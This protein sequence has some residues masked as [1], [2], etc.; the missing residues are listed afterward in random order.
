MNTQL[1]YQYKQLKIM[2]ETLEAEWIEHKRLH[3][4]AVVAQTC[5]DVQPI[6]VPLESKQTDDVGLLRCCTGD[7]SLTTSQTCAADDDLQRQ[8]S[9]SFATRQDPALRRPRGFG[10]STSSKRPSHAEF[11][12][13]SDAVSRVMQ[14]FHVAVDDQQL[15]RS[16]N[17]KS[18]SSSPTLFYCVDDIYEHPAAVLE[19]TSSLVDGQPAFRAKNNNN[20]D[21]DDSLESLFG[22]DDWWTTDESCRWQCGSPAGLSVSEATRTDGGSTKLKTDDCLLT[23]PSNDLPISL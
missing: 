10:G 23:T 8:A 17:S 9:T 4:T 13:W 1:I 2:K 21:D 16:S 6:C 3:E 7:R 22:G 12:G 20:A 5:D 15:M 14:T 18:S 11:N 19:P